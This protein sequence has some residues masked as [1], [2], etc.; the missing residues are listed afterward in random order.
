MILPLKKEIQRIKKMLNE[1]LK[2]AMEKYSYDPEEPI[3][4]K[5]KNKLFFIESTQLDSRSSIAAERQW[6]LERR[7]RHTTTIGTMTGIMNLRR[8]SILQRK[9][10][11]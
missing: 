8:I 6:H 11:I 2:E 10:R 9:N 4:E 3:E 5:R 7:I 1:D